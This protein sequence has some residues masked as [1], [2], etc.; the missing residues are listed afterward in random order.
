MRQSNYLYQHLH[1][2]NYSAPLFFIHSR[3]SSLLVL[4]NDIPIC[5]SI[6]CSLT[7][8][9]EHLCVGAV[10][11]KSCPQSRIGRDKTDNQAI[12]ETDKVMAMKTL[13]R[14]AFMLSFRVV[15]VHEQ[16]II[17]HELA[18]LPRCGK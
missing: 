9:C 15:N 1:L 16:M 10:T 7:L 13:S 3:L 11:L 8:V 2:P 6:H 17:S 18:A 4:P 12:D 14:L 5:S